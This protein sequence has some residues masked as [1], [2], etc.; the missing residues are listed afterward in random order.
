MRTELDLDGPQARFVLADLDEGER[1]AARDLWFVEDGECFVKRFDAAAGARVYPR[2]AACAG[3]L[4]D[5]TAALARPRWEDALETLLDRAGEG[6]WWLGG[7]GALA[8]RGVEVVPRDLDLVTSQ[9]GAE[10]LAHRLDDLLVEPL[11]VRDGWIAT[12]FARTFAGA[13]IEWIG[14]VSVDAAGARDF[15]PAAEERLETVR[16]RGRAIRVP[17]L[18][19]QLVSARARGLAERVTAI[20]RLEHGRKRRPPLER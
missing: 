20:E 19:L 9:A 16:W 7:S 15:G 14:G 4:L 2:F 18:D 1:S 6:D 3:D 5:Q 8:V 12:H 10:E 13:R 17:P 11:T